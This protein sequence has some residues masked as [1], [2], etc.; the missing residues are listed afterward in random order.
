ML[1]A[2]PLEVGPVGPVAAEHDVDAAGVP[3]RLYN[4]GAPPGTGVI[5]FLHGGGW[6]LGDLETHDGL[7]RRL[8]SYSGC[9]V[10]SVAYRLAPEHPHPAQ[11]EDVEAAVDWLRS[12][13]GGLNVDARRLVVAGDSAG[14]FLAA[15]AA[16]RARDAGVP[17]AAQILLYPVIDAPGAYPDLDEYG[18]S[19]DEM[20]FFWD[21][22]APAPADRGRPDLAPME[23]SLTDLPPSLILTAEL[24]ILRAE[25]EEYAARLA[26]SG[27]AVTA[28]RYLGVNHGF[29]R[30]FALFDAADD[31][32]RQAAAA[33]RRALIPP[34]S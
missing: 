27:V 9:P 22:F 7:C 30:K 2:V 6:V 12:N 15:I 28:V 19:R 13:A 8:A 5:V 11:I 1:D 33:C 26:A 20:R 17:Y 29:A 24:D 4:P 21:A 31:A 18:L 25:G 10:F 16:R 14:G 34:L 23:G 32:A 3:C